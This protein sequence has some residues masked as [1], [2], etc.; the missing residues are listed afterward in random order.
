MTE[1]IKAGSQV[2]LNTFKERDFQ[3]TFKKMAKA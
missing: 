2:V 1:V 3:D